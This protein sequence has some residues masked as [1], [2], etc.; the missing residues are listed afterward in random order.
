MDNGI[1]VFFGLKL[2]VICIL[3]R[4]FNLCNFLCFICL[5]AGLV[6]ICH[7]RKKN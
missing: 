7:D 2:D 5:S 1:V 4:Y 3:K 6:L